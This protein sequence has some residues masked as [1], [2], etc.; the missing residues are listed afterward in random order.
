[1]PLWTLF[2]LRKGKAT[3]PWPRQRRC[4]GQEG[5]L[6]MPRFEP[7]LR[8]RLR[9]MRRGLPDRGDHG[10]RPDEPAGAARGRLRPLRRLPA[11]RRS[12][13]DRR[14]DRLLRLGLRRRATAPDLLLSATSA[15]RA[16]APATRR[17]AAGFRRSL[18]IRH[19]DAGSCNGCE[20]ELQAL[21]NPFYNLHR[22]GI[23]FTPSPRFADLLLVTG[24]VTYAMHEPLR[25]DLRGDA[26]AALGHGGRHLRGLGRHRRRRLCLRQRP[27]RRAA[28]RSLSAGLPAQ[29]G[30]D[31]RGAADVPRPRAAAGEGR[32]PCRMTCCAAALAAWLVA[33]LL[34]LTGRA[35]RARRAC[36]SA[37]GGLALH[38]RWPSLALAGRDCRRS[39]LPLGM[40]GAASTFALAPEAL[41]LMGFGLPGA[42]LACLARH[43][44]AAAERAGCSA[45]RASLIGALGVFGLQDAA[46]F[47]VAWEIMS[48]GGAVMILGERLARETGRPVL[49]MLALLEAGAVA[50]LLAFILLAGHAGSLSFA[51]F[52]AAARAMPRA[53]QLFVGLLLLIGF[54]AKLGLLPFYEWFPGAYGAGSGATG[55]LLSGVVL[56]AAFFGLSRG[57]IDWLPVDH[58]SPRLD[59]RHLHRR[60]RRAQRDPDGALCLPAGRLAR[61]AEPFLGRERLDRGLP[62]GRGADVPPGRA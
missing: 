18:H 38:R 40:A 45:P 35:A 28:G 56:N 49:F 9:G 44:G 59:R 6:G 10:R 27:G 53:E 62:A 19:V 43:A 4:D 54:G 41:W 17:R 31:H 7:E 50:L 22:L 33:A 52:A 5:V 46:S 13:P 39:A 20:S 21:N 24:P 48:L 61:A 26:G 14:G 11:L 30:G 23:F 25:R 29:S 8:D 2:G 60:R 58:A 15:R 12:L 32:P 47:L 36:C 57:L 3:T 34:A 55:A 37:L 16:A 1:M 51:D 42:I